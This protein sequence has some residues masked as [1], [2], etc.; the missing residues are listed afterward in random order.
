[1]DELT[2]KIHMAAGEEYG[3]QATCRNGNKI[4][5]Q[6]ETK[7]CKAALRMSEKNDRDMEG[8]PCFWCGGWH[9]GRTLT[10]LE[11]ERFK[12]MVLARDALDFLDAWAKGA[13]EIL[14]GA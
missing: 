1:M 4:N 6:T 11:I 12:V 8:Y 13:M 14:S 10:E 5:Y 2:R 7:A 3:R 9:V